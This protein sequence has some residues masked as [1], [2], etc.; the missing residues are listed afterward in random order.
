MF[1][2]VVVVVVVWFCSSSWPPFLILEYLINL[3]HHFFSP[4]SYSLW[5]L[6]FHSYT[7]LLYSCEAVSWAE[8]YCGALGFFASLSNAVFRFTF[9]HTSKLK[10]SNFLNDFFLSLTLFARVTSILNLS[11]QTLEKRDLPDSIK[12]TFA[13][14]NLILFSISLRSKE[15]ICAVKL[16]NKRILRNEFQRALSIYSWMFFYLAFWA[17]SIF[18]SI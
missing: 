10:K 16:P 14:Q 17:A 11:R 12:M 18:F 15:L 13:L 6:S 5:R 9:V 4:L 1:V 7:I 8:L 2:V 3:M